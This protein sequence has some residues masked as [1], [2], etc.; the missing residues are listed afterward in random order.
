IKQHGQYEGDAHQ[1]VPECH[2]AEA[3]LLL[4][5]PSAPVT[6][7]MISAVPALPPFSQL[8]RSP[9][10]KAAAM[11]AVRRCDAWPS[12]ALPLRSPSQSSIIAA[13][14]S[15]AAGLARPLPMMSGPVPWQGWKMA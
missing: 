6:R 14:S 13:D 9:G 4:P 5:S 3:F 8:T 15:M 7:V 2:H 11:A 12:A 1:A 10:A